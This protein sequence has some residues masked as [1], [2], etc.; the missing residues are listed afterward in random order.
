MCRQSPNASTLPC[1]D[2][3]DCLTVP[4]DCQPP[5]PCSGAGMIATV[6]SC[7][8]AAGGWEPFLPF[9]RGVIHEWGGVAMKFAAAFGMWF[10]GELLYMRWSPTHLDWKSMDWGHIS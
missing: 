6:A 10:A 8:I 7:S 5:P 3:K 2:S 9:L 4:N 1:S